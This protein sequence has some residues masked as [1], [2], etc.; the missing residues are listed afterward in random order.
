MIY[1]V[2]AHG[3]DY[4]KIGQSINV[5][6]RVSTL[7]TA[8]PKKLQV[9]AVLDGS[10]QTEAGIHELFKHLRKNG[11]W[12]KKTDELKYF[13]RAIQRNPE[14]NNI[15]TLYRL[16][17]QLRLREKA[18]RLSKNGNKKLLEKINSASRRLKYCQ[19]KRS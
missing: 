5:E 12:F 17:M 3:L 6:S 13:I 11:E 18:A 14:E 7:Q 9:W 8:S 10:Y 1:F 4:I 15:Y 2:T 19:D 16:S